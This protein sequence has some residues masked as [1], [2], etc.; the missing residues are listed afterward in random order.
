MLIMMAR[1]TKRD[2]QLWASVLDLLNDFHAFVKDKK[3]IKGKDRKQAMSE[4]ALAD[5]TIWLGE[6]EAAE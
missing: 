6:K 1:L 4:R 3:K 5:L 2:R